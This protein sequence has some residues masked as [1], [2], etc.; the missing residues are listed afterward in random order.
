MRTLI[1]EDDFTAR[2]TLQRFLSKYGEC[3][4]AVSGKEAVAAFRMAS[5]AGSGYDLICMDILLPEMDGQEAVRQIRSLER[6]R[7]ILS[8]GGAKIIMTTSVD[9][10]KDVI[11]SFQELCDAYLVKPV[12]LGALRDH[13][14]AFGLV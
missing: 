10:M 6:E 8:S 14:R 9:E 1:V 12:N 4:I 7:G 11:R 13:L 2:L 3:D 5:E